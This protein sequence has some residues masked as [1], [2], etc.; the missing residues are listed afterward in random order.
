MF[1]SATK[2]TSLVLALCLIG[3]FIQAQQLRVHLTWAAQA[4]PLIY[5]SL[6]DEVVLISNDSFPVEVTRIAPLDKIELTNYRG[7][8]RLS[9]NGQA[10]GNFK[11]IRF[12]ANDDDPKFNLMF[13][14]GK[15][16]RTYADNLEV[17]VHAAKLR[18]I[19][20]VY[21]ENYIKGVVHAEAGNHKSLEFFK[22]QAV[23][24]RT[25]ALNNRD[26]HAKQGFELCDRTHCQAYKGMYKSAPLIDKAVTQ[27]MSEVILADGDM[28]ID[29]VFSANCGGHTANSEDVWIR[30]IDYLRAVPDYNYCEGFSNHSWHA[31]V[32][33]E[34]FLHKV[35]HY[36]RVKAD[37]FRVDRDKSGRVKRIL[38]N[39]NSMLS[40]SGEELR[41]MFNFRSS[42]F[43]ILDSGPGLVIDGAG[44]GHGVGMC[45][46]GAYHL[47][48]MGLDYDK[49]IKHY[50]RGVEIGRFGTTLAVVDEN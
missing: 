17:K 27:T 29:A 25:Y 26:K 9:K 50:Y 6:S 45:Q 30:Q 40:I 3:T 47:S 34:D 12:W 23:S 21:L 8:V 5:Q 46:D 18:V 24:A 11:S 43:Q 35:G 4:E 39:D 15:S 13:S 28:L 32:S 16:V 36:H 2:R 49:I 14:S 33:K 7:R 31:S 48:K 10:L 41:R 44:F 1:K 38:V 20:E 19:N 37:S 42:K 22:V